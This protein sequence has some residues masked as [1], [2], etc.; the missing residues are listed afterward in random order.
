MNFKF[1]TLEERAA[2]QVLAKRGIALEAG[3]DNPPDFDEMFSSAEPEADETLDYM[4]DLLESGE[5][6]PEEFRRQLLSAGYDEAAISDALQG[7]ADEDE[8]GPH[9]F[10]DTYG[11]EGCTCRMETV[12]SASID[13]PEPIL[14]QWCPV[15]GR[16]DVDA[17]NDARRDDALSSPNGT[18]K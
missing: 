1:K 13:P 17:M 11:C 2:E 15:H 12:H 7:L 3:Y 18:S 16:R 4:V 6:T 5:I 8:P 14:N 9:N 10:P